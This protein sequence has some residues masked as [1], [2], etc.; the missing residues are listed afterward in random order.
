LLTSYIKEK[1][2]EVRQDTRNV[3]EKVKMA[4]LKKDESV[5]PFGRKHDEVEAKKKLFFSGSSTMIIWF[6]CKQETQRL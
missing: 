3:A 5:T 1:R 6:L 4:K 2:A